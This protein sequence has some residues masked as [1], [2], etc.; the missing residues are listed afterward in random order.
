[1]DAYAAE[2]C[3]LAVE[4]ILGGPGQPENMLRDG[5]ADVAVLHQ[6]YDA[7]AGFDIEVLHTE[8]QVAV[9][10]AGHRLADRPHVSMAD[11]N[12]LT[13][14]P[15]PR[16]PRRDGTYADGPGPQVR[17]HTQLFQLIALGLACAV[18]PESLR[19]QVRDGHAVVPVS[20]APAVTTVIAWPP[21]ST[22]KGLADLVRT[23]VHL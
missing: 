1:L 19:T 18:V 4:V 21:H 17:D 16:W 3:A 10:P 5:R 14:L 20:D 13:D 12:A 2:P 6:P 7:L 11:V 23:A 15:L 22:S 8:Q 9:L